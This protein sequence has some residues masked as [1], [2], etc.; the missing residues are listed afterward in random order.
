MQYLLYLAYTYVYII[1]QQTYIIMGRV[2]LLSD[3]IKIILIK[4][5]IIFKY[6]IHNSKIFLTVHYCINRKRFHI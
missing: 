2:T 5:I 4:I 1:I 3:L 6:I